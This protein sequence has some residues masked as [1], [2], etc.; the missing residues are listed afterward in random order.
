MVDELVE[1]VEGWHEIRPDTV[2]AVVAAL[3]QAED[4]REVLDDVVW[5]HHLARRSR[6]RR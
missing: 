5:R 6:R 4:V 2:G 1:L 3:D